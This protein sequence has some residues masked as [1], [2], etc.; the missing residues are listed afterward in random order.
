MERPKKRTDAW[1]LLKGSCSSEMNDKVITYWMFV[2]VTSQVQWSGLW[3]QLSECTVRI[4]QVLYDISYISTQHVEISKIYFSWLGRQKLDRHYIKYITLH[5]ITLQSGEY[6]QVGVDCRLVSSSPRP[7]LSVSSPS[8]GLATTHCS[9]QCEH[10]GHFQQ[11][12]LLGFLL[13]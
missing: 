12:F 11:L 10:C 5:Y 8:A 7:Q 2:V 13:L 9:H 3:S 4:Y 1:S 6:P